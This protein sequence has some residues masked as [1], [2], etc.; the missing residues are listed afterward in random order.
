M[1][2]DLA[3]NGEEMWAAFRKCGTR[4][5]RDPDI[6][7]WPEYVSLSTRP[8]MIRSSIQGFCRLGYQDLKTVVE[9]LF[10][11]PQWDV[12]EATATVLSTLMAGMHKRMDA[13]S[14]NKEVEKLIRELLKSENRRVRFAAVEAAFGT[15]HYDHGIL[16]LEAVKQLSRDPNCRVRGICAEN[17]TDCVLKGGLGDFNAVELLEEFTDTLVFWFQHDRSCWLLDQLF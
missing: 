7:F 2:K 16:F 9:A 6:S 11:H 1:N 15:R 4:G 10:A 13:S 17:L 14:L 12:G 3:R 5:N 8:S